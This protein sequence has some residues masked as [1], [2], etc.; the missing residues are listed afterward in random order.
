MVTF[1]DMS[2]GNGGSE[3]GRFAER[4]GPTF[5]WNWRSVLF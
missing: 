2:L 4:R 1:V 3:L 5:F